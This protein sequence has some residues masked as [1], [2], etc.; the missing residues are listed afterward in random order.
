VEAKDDTVDQTPL[1]FAASYDHID[2]VQALVER[3]A[4]I[5]ARDKFGWTALM[6]A[7]GS[8]NAAIVQFLIDSGGCQCD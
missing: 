6:L 1:I 2:T 3:W 5:N 4:N 8:G 7:A